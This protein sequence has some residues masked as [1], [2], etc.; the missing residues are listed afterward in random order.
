MTVLSQALQIRELPPGGLTGR[1]CGLNN[2]AFSTGSQ[3]WWLSTLVAHSDHQGEI[4]KTLMNA[5]GPLP[6]I[7]T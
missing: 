6:E 2:Q 5:G 4:S 7:L 3:E 1:L